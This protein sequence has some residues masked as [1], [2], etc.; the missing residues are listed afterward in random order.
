MSE[1]VYPDA[2]GFKVAGPSEQAAKAITGS[3]NKM[4]AAVLAQIAQYPGGATA[5]EIAK[6]L[7]LLVLSVR[8][9]VSELN[10]NGEIQQTGARRKNESGM[11][12]TVWRVR[13]QSSPPIGGE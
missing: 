10:R 7:N 4:R 12:A 6:D 1:L 5:D 11:T 3:A 9:R 2:P 13:P 8:P